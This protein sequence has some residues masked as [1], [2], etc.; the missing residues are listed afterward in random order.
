MASYDYNTQTPDDDDSS[1]GVS[2]IVNLNLGVGDAAEKVASGALHIAGKVAG[3]GLHITG[4][5]LRGIFR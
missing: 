1:S 4:K 2:P 3:A 5:I